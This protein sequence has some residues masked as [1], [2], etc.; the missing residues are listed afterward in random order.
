MEK[1]DKRWLLRFSN[2]QRALQI[3]EEGASLAKTRTLSN[4]ERQ[5]LIKAFDCTHELA[6]NV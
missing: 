3:L 1:N 2:F 4:L 5:G 6:W